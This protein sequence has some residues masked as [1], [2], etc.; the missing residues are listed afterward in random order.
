[1]LKRLIFVPEVLVHFSLSSKINSLIYVD[2]FLTSA[3]C[4]LDLSII[5]LKAQCVLYYGFRI[6]LEVG[7][8]QSPNSVLFQYSVDDSA[9]FVSQY[10]IKNQFVN[11]HKIT[12][13][14]FVWNCTDFI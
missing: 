8:Y 5:S 2:Q 11:L 12:C 1:M 10:K 13:C 7:Y 14:D 9:S 4:S 6:R 3:L